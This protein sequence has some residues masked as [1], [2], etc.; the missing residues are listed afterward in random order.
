MK[1]KMDLYKF[2]SNT[3]LRNKSSV[4]FPLLDTMVTILSFFFSYWLTNL[5]V[6]EY[7]TFTIEYLYML[8]LI[9]PT[10]VIL[11]NNSIL[12]SIPRTRT[13]LSIF[14]KLLNFNFIGF[15]LIFLYKHLLGFSVFSHY[16]II[17]FSVFNLLALFVLRMLT[18]RVF[19]Y[20]RASGHNIH[21]V[22]IY[23]DDL[24]E[25]IISDIFQHKEW[26]F[27]ILMILTDSEVLRK[28]YG[29][30]VRVFPDKISI[31]EIIKVDI[32]DEVIYCKSDLNNNRIESLIDT[33]E[34]IGVIFRL[35]S[36]LSPMSYTNAYLTN[37]NDISFLTFA[38]VPKNRFAVAWKSF[39]DFW[40]SFCIIFL[41]SPFMLLIAILIK[42]SSVGPIIF[43]QER[44]GL[45]GR[46]FYIY[47]F[48][49]M[50]NDAEKL[51]AKL[52]ALNE[53]DG[54]A[55]KIKND[56]RIT[57]VGRFLRKTGLDELPQLFNVLKGEMSLIGPRPPLSEEVKKYEPWQLRRL[58]VKP[59]ITCTW[60]IIPN[61]NDVIFE[62]WM[63]LDMQYIDNWSLKADF[64][65]FFRTIFT[66][67]RAG[68]H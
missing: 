34:E 66:V 49:T 22:I 58:S 61:R 12:S 41:L 33:C 46:K 48:R 31:K 67:F 47:K 64:I 23:A 37:F 15:L 5:I 28:K 68:G 24:S 63:K 13:T 3:S 25:N 42:S 35:Q 44:V 39:M 27:R 32:I 56:P 10:W 19:K 50:V 8:L 20:F 16:F 55:F 53:S 4:L 62:K 40:I 30:V 54:P 17:S 7:F 18:Y 43:K 65:L 2:F 1:H 21:N 59:G 57:P 29:K 6:K 9:I 52:L 14:F 36:N 26:G 51:K 60:Q 38:N 11:L 45:R